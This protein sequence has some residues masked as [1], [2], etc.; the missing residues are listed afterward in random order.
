MRREGLRVDVRAIFTTPT[1]AGL[2]AAIE[3]N[4]LA[5]EIKVPINPLS[6]Q[7]EQP[8]DNS[9]MEEGVI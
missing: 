3:I 9:N 1:V 8:H 6:K 4:A 5:N 7:D 2:G